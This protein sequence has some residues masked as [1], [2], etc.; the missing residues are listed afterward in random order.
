MQECSITLIDN[1]PIIS[2]NEIKRNVNL[3]QLVNFIDVNLARH[4]S[5]TYAYHREH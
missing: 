3:M 4:V 1:Y 5:G 2:T